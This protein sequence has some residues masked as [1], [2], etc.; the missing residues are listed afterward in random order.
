MWLLSN[1]ATVPDRT[2]FNNLFCETSKV[3]A[4]STTDAKLRHL[5]WHQSNFWGDRASSLSTSAF[6]LPS[7]RSWLQA[8]LKHE[9]SVYFTK[10]VVKSSY[11]MSWPT[12]WYSC[13]KTVRSLCQI[14]GRRRTILTIYHG[15]RQSFRTTAA[16][17]SC[18]QSRFPLFTSSP[19]RNS[20]IVLP[21]NVTALQ[22]QLNAAEA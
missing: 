7:R 8:D 2:I 15:F 21:L 19:I 16:F 10:K 12:G 4:A 20:T 3:T 14:S 17:R 1:R 9:L 5:H 22:L 13:F 11:W 6:R 18:K